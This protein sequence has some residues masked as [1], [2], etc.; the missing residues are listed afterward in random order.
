M[1]D[2]VRL[3]R[4]SVEPVPVVRLTLTRPSDGVAL[5]VPVTP[6]MV[7]DLRDIAAQDIVLVR[8]GSRLIILFADGPT[9]VL[10][11]FYGPDGQPIA[12]VEVD[13]GRGATIAATDIVTPRPRRLAT[14]SRT[15]PAGRT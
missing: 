9:I 3:A 15:S 5:V 7:L 1:N 4:N 14:A 13:V 10:A 8:S 2:L 6:G 12:G 11:G